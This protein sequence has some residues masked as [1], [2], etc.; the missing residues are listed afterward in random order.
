MKN[1]LHNLIY[2]FVL[3]TMMLSGAAWSEEDPVYTTY[4]SSA[5]AE[6]YDVTAYFSEAKPVKGEEA[7]KMEYMGA[8]WY[9]ANQENLDKFTQSPQKYAPQYGGYCAYAV[10]QGSTAR[11]DPL[12]WTIHE[13]KLYLNY[14]NEI[15]DRW[16]GDKEQFIVKADKHWP[17]VL[18]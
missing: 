1:Y 18:N 9:F 4:F 6:G 2:L 3:A 17:T 14:N 12:L 7:F 10:S 8:D 16:R 11:G 5:A 13:D 15:S